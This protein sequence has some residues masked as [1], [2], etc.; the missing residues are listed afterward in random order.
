LY[1][2]IFILAVIYFTATYQNY[3]ANAKLS[4]FLNNTSYFGTITVET[5]F[6]NIITRRHTD[7]LVMMQSPT[8]ELILP[9]TGLVRQSIIERNRL[10]HALT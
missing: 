9:S 2:T 1:A 10:H 6:I 4:E 8:L 7:T 3:K 5:I